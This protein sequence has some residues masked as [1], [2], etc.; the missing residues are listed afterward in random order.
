MSSSDRHTL[1][2][3]G[4][5][6]AARYL[7]SKGYCILARNWRC[8]RL[9]IDLIARKDRLYVFVEVKT[10]RNLEYGRPEEA[11]SER[12][13]RGIVR[14]ADS[15]LRIHRVDNPV[16]FDIVSVLSSDGRHFEINHI[17][18]AFYPLVE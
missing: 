10:R 8:G 2:K 17:E 6:M 4:E 1:G 9:E 14:A 16:R 13:M 18:D 3:D 7:E 11:V 5:E 12:K 15:Y